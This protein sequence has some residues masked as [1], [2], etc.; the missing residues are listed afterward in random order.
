[1]EYKI[2]E[3]EAKDN[4]VV[5]QII[6]T[7]LTEFGGNREGL[8]W[9]DPYLGRLSEVY[10][11]EGT[12]Y[13]VVEKSDGK[14]V[15]GAGIGPW[16]SGKGICELQKMYFLQE[17]RGTGAAQELMQLALKY[18][19]IYYKQCYIETLH[20]ME[21]ANRFYKKHGFMQLEQPLSQTEH[22]ACD[23]WYIKEL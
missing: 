11:P 5:E 18:A 15:G 6:R 16:P 7:C 17:A 2:R 22:F 21:A 19:K 10:E 23:V 1:M 20:N 9:A 12:C 13:W 8:A 3:I 4:A 14:I